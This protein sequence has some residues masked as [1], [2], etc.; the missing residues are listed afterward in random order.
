[1]NSSSAIADAVTGPSPTITSTKPTI[2]SMPATVRLIPTP[3]N[4]FRTNT[5]PTHPTPSFWRV[6]QLHQSMSQ[7]STGESLGMDGATRRRFASWRAIV[8]TVR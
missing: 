2:A 5:P 1:M 4:R 7:L 6:R 3:T 8:P